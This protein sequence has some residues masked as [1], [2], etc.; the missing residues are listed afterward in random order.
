MKANRFDD[1]FTIAHSSSLCRST[2]LCW[3]R[4]LRVK[5]Y[6]FWCDF[7]FF[8]HKIRPSLQTIART[9]ICAFSNFSIL[10]QFTTSIDDLLRTVFQACLP[11]APPRRHREKRSGVFLDQLLHTLLKSILHAF[12]PTVPETGNS[13]HVFTLPWVSISQS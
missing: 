8:G 9:L 3:V 7:S 5:K 13:F 4:I 2:T 10:D 12:F 11:A 6:F 1:G